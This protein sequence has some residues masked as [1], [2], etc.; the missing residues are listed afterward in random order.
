MSARP[1]RSLQQ[2]PVGITVGRVDQ[3]VKDSTV[4]PQL[5]VPQVR[6]TGNV[7]LD[8][9]YLGGSSAEIPGRSR[10]RCAGYVQNRYT[11]TKLHEM[12]GKSGRTTPNVD[13]PRVQ[14]R[15]F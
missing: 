13:Y 6:C 2:T 8:P 14:R 7:C 1:Y 10:H 4:V 12:P 5:E 9:A 15:S 3:K 11:V